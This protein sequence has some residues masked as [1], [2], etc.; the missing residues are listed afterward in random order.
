M[1]IHSPR[2]NASDFIAV[3]GSPMLFSHQCD[4][5][6]FCSASLFIHSFLTPSRVFLPRFSLTFSKKP[7]SFLGP[8]P[9][10]P[11]R[12]CI[13]SPN[14][15]FSLHQN[16]SIFSLSESYSSENTQWTSEASI[17]LDDRVAR[18]DSDGQQKRSRQMGCPP[19]KWT[20]TR[21]RKL[22]RLYLLTHLE[23]DGITNLLRTEDFHSWLA[24]V[25]ALSPSL[26]KFS[27]G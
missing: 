24:H 8:W 21:L 14:A 10:S 18:R 6:V 22:I 20:C 23:L 15:K 11:F 4:S 1:K 26:D 27:C 2:L 12:S 5:Q 13:S 3:L 19:N 25:F 7:P 16:Q 9:Q 17:K